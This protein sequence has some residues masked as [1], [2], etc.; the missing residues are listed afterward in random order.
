M[1]RPLRIEYPAAYYHVLNRG[2]HGEDI[3]I[4]DKDRKVFLDGLADSC[5]S[6]RIKLIAYV[7][8]SN[9][10]HL[11]FQTPQANLSEFMRHFLV[12]YTV[13]F[14]RRNSRTGHLFLSEA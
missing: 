5:E 2:N 10:F 6:Y 7:S 3:F 13:R 11:L 1:A 12:T 4:A 8:M 14:N 9:H